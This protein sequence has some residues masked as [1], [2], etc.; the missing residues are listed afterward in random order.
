VDAE[1]NGEL[2]DAAALDEEGEDEK[3]Q[4]EVVEDLFGLWVSP[5]AV[6]VLVR[7]VVTAEE[8]ATADLVGDGVLAIAEDGEE[9]GTHKREAGRSAIT[10]R[11]R[12][13]RS[14]FF[15]ACFHR[16]SPLS[17]G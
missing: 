1:R 3:V 12:E 17:N 13:S 14:V 8:D 5:A 7:A 4:V 9:P 15:F 6:T 11:K 2:E 10:Q 16:F